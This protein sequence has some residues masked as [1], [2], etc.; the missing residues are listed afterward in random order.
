M[1]RIY[2]VRHGQT[3]WNRQERFR[4]RIDIPLNEVGHDQARA[5]AAYLSGHDI[6]A[7]YTS[8]L[9]RAVQT[10]LPIAQ[11]HDLSPTILPG[12]IDISY[13]EWQGYSPSEVRDEFPDLL[14]LWYTEPHRV[15]IPG[16]QNLKTIKEQ[17]MSV[18]R[19]TLSRHDNGGI[20]LVTHQIV[21]KVLTCT[22]LGL[23]VSQIWRIRQDN[24]CIDVF[25][26][27]K[28]QFTAIL[29]NGTAHLQSRS[30][31]ALPA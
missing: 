19:E 5:V 25:A 16:G 28:E 15:D 29:I 20:V 14:E 27:D 4:G 18:V 24:A 11:V 13:G 10:A 26:W 1:T 2:L 7:V 6:V 3:E 30:D 17:A 9:Q 23:E 31:L 21:I 12:L 22:L 8:P